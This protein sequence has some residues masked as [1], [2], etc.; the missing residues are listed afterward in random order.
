MP[1]LQDAEHV[2]DQDLAQFF[3]EVLRTYRQLAER[4]KALLRQRLR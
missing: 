1:Y 2:G 3:R 4:G